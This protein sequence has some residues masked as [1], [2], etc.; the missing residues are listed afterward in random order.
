MDPKPGDFKKIRDL[1][2]RLRFHV[3]EPVKI[4]GNM[5][6][7]TCSI[8]LPSQKR[9][10]GANSS[11]NTSTNV[12]WSEFTVLCCWCV[13]CVKYGSRWRHSV[14]KCFDFT[15][16][17]LVA[18][19][20]N[21]LQTES[22]NF[23]HQ[24]KKYVNVFNWLILHVAAQ[25]SNIVCLVFSCGR[26]MCCP[27]GRKYLRRSVNIYAEAWIFTPGPKYFRRGVNIYAGR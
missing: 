14:C 22:D 24:L 9:L 27:P 4:T 6:I 16:L 15:V 8:Y 1:H 18:E 23:S 17:F 3:L 5:I 10:F 2:F 13:N 25:V 11:I 20:R 12:K 19:A 21:A 26:N 7:G